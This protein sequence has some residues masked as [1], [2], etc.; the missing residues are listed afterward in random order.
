MIFQ[1]RELHIGDRLVSKRHGVIVVDSICGPSF[2]ARAIST[3][4]IYDWDH[5]GYYWY[6][7]DN[8]IDASW[9][10]VSTEQAPSPSQA[11]YD[12]MIDFMDSCKP[13]AP[14]V[15]REAEYR[16]IWIERAAKCYDY[17]VRGDRDAS[18]SEL[19]ETAFVAADAFLAAL[20][21]RDGANN[22]TD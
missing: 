2:Y 6:D 18:F 19:A 12:R 14:D 21:K 20:K 7:D 17:E 11:L 5:E 13:P 10:D 1:G 3:G 8:I 22:G 4:T 9:P 15:Q 16:R